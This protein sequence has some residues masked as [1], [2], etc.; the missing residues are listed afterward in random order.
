MR[1]RD[2][3][4]GASS[5]EMVLF[6]NII[7][8]LFFSTTGIAADKLIYSSDL[9][10][11]GAFK[12]PTGTYGTSSFAYSSGDMTYNPTNNS[13]FISGH[14]YDQGH[15]AEVNIP[16]P[17]NSTNLGSLPEATVRQN[18]ADISEGH[19]EQIGAG[20]S[21]C[22]GTSI[23]F[24]GM[25]VYGNKLVGTSFMPYDG[26]GCSVLS[27]FYSSKTVASTGD[28]RGMYQ[29]SGM[30]GASFVDKA[31]TPVP[32]GWQS[33]LGGPAL[34]GATGMSIVSRA[35]W[36]PDAFSFDPDKLGVTDPLPATPLLYYNETHKMY[37]TVAWNQTNPYWNGTTRIEGM[38]F[39]QNSR[40][41]LFSGIHGTGTYCYGDVPPCVDPVS[42]SKGDHSTKYDF[43]FWAY[44][45]DDLVSVKN[46][47]KQPW[48]PLPYAVWNVT[49]PF[50]GVKS[51]FEV[52]GSAYDPATQ[53]LYLMQA[54]GNSDWPVIHVYQVNVTLSTGPPPVPPGSIPL[55]PTQ[56]RITP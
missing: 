16:T 24:G 9:T 40:T 22:T 32:A 1:N 54:H 27:H 39:I 42:N 4:L 12:L 26:G 17:V 20:G 33:S 52:G 37:G 18:F 53:R 13:L 6:I 55:A 31:M 38:H 45:V 48:E 15:V 47:T 8:L 49:L 46:G 44:N 36:G 2:K 50:G 35:S 25:M 28:F 34:T 30:P 14:V 41:L 7:I 3:N 5:G 56:I 19:L 10:Y 43:Q 11:L 51:I 29:L 23:A 21:S